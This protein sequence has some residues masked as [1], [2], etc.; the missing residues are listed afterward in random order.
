MATLSLV[1]GSCEPPAWRLG[2]LTIRRYRPAEFDTVLALHRDGLAQVGLRPGD[3][4]YYEHDLFEM[5][6]LYL[7]NGGEFLVGELP[8]ASIVAMGGL[9]RLS[10]DEPGIGEMVR[11]RVRMD[12]QR[13]GFGT[14][15]V[16]A[17]EQRAAELGYRELRADTTGF[18][19]AALELYRRFGWRETHRR[20]INGIVNVYLAKTLSSDSPV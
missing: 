9:R 16:A 12:V 4:V 7:G 14:A 2:D 18:Q 19:T 5:E 10:A 20:P 1:R 17:L 6:R 15:M 3:G 11:L 8:D 13:R